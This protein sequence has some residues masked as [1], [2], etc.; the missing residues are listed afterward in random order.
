MLGT[1]S[2][3]TVSGTRESGSKTLRDAAH[4]WSLVF[5]RKGL[6]R[7]DRA[8]REV[9]VSS[10]AGP[11]MGAGRGAGLNCGPMDPVDACPLE[12]RG[13]GRRGASLRVQGFVP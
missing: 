1:I 3:H 13:E 12:A 11:E 8:P 4:C 2:H 10:Q 7:S 5:V 9:K 6:H